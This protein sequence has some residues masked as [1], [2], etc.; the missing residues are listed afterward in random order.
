MATV[1][2]NLGPLTTPFTYPESCKVI[3]QGCSACY[4]GWQGQTYSVKQTNKELRGWG[5]YSPGISCPAG[6]EKR[7]S[8]TGT[9]DVSGFTFQF[10]LGYTCKFDWDVDRA[11]TCYSIATTGSFPAVFCS[12][13]KSNGFRYLELPTAAI[14]TGSGEDS[15]TVI[16]T[17][18]LNAPLFQLIHQSTDIASSSHTATVTGQS[19]I[20]GTGTPP[21]NSENGLSIAAKAGIGG[22]VGGGVLLV[23]MAISFFFW[24]RKRARGA[25]STTAGTVPSPV[26]KQELPA[27]SVP[28]LELSTPANS[29]TVRGELA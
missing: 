19:R 27:I 25:V 1:R 6:Y 7:C 29:P 4:W 15:V 11:H 10:P 9:A 13:G 26:L 24:K 8:A 20:S 14:V 17:M 16:S 21:N 3:V 23:I 12:S 18:I 28:R 5:Y 22:G 2:T